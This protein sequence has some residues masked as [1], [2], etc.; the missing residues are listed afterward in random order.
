MAKQYSKEFKREAVRLSNLDDRNCV[1]VAKEL[2]I[3]V[4]LPY[5]WQSEAKKSGGDAFPGKGSQTPEEA[6]ISKLKAKVHQLEEEREILKK[7]MSIFADKE[8]A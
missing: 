2:G 1:N 5:R 6:E 3:R 7:P 4:K 8:R